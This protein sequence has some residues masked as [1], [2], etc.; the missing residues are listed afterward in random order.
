MSKRN[1]KQAPKASFRFKPMK[2]SVHKHHKKQ[3]KSIE[4]KQFLSIVLIGAILLV[5]FLY[6]V[7]R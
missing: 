4:T 6:I 3:D 5:W 2:Q 1:L 7:L